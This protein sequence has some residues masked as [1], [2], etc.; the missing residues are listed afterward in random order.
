MFHCSLIKKF[1]VFFCL[2]SLIVEISCQKVAISVSQSFLISEGQSVSINRFI[3]KNSA[4]SQG[5]AIYNDFVFVAKD[6]G[7][8]EVYRYSD[9]EFESSFDLSTLGRSN[10]CNC[11]NW[12]MPNEATREFPFLYISNGRAGSPDE[13]VCVVNEIYRDNNRFSSKFVQKITLDVSEFSQY[14]LMV[15]WGGPQWLV[16]V[17]RECIWVWSADIRTLPYFTGDFSRNRYH[18]TCF[19]I[20]D[21]SEGESVVFTAEDVLDQVSFDFDAYTTQGGCASNGII[22]YSFGFGDLSSPSKIRVFD[23]DSGC[24][25]HRI[26]LARVLDVELEDLAYYNDRLYINT[27]SQYIY[28]LKFDPA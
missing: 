19:R 16:D 2:L 1:K 14:G 3:K 22:F 13:W 4:S 18:A 28:E 21:I 27:I 10:H 24:I 11:I 12:G 17:E 15:P 25:I 5:L 9:Q 6:G 23:T 7:V 26:D 8:C 20:P